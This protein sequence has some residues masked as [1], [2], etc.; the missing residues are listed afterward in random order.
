[1][2]AG[3]GRQPDALQAPGERVVAEVRGVDSA[4]GLVGEDEAAGLVE[5]TRPVH[6]R[7]LALQRRERRRGLPA[8]EWFERRAPGT[9][10]LRRVKDE[11]TEGR[12]EKEA[13]TFALSPVRLA[14]GLPDG[15]LRSRIA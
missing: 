4:A 5:G 11:M 3:V 1:M 6:L 7:Y 15:Q 2:K 12:G 13:I 9:E 10:T 14:Q 8:E